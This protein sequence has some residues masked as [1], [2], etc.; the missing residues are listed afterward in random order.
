MPRFLIPKPDLQIEGYPKLGIRPPQALIWKKFFGPKGIL[1]IREGGLGDIL[2]C[3]P[4]IKAL[5]QKYNLPLTFATLQKFFCLLEG[6]PSIDHLVD[7]ESLD[8][9]GYGP[10]FDARN[11]LEDYSIPRNRVHRIDSLA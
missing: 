11:Q 5:K 9:A 7:I 2:M 6:N 1:F 10:I 3:T 4:I 8:A